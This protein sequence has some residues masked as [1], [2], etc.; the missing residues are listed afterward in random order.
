MIASAIQG[1]EASLGQRLWH[2]LLDEPVAFVIR[3]MTADD[4]EGRLLRSN[5]PFSVLI[6]ETD[7]AHRRRTRLMAKEDMNKSNR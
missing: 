7:Q 6:G 2:R 5:N 1:G 3:C 4:A